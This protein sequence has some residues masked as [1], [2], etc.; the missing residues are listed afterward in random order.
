MKS[1][2]LDDTALIFIRVN[3]LL[4]KQTNKVWFEVNGSIVLKNIK[5]K[6]VARPA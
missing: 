5:E 6:V 4:P 3:Y 2:I 1:R